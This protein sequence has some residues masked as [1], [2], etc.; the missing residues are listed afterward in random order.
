MASTSSSTEILYRPGQN[1]NIYTG[2]STFVTSVPPDTR[3]PI[4]PI[5]SLEAEFDATAPMHSLQSSN[6][7]AENQTSATPSS[8]NHFEALHLFPPENHSQVPS[9]TP[10]DLQQPTFPTDLSPVSG[11]DSLT[12]SSAGLIGHSNSPTRPLGF[13]YFSSSSLILDRR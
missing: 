5:I 7:F 9:N 3:I 8:Y 13:V 2:P 4:D 6:I 11:G 1:D 10:W 12:E